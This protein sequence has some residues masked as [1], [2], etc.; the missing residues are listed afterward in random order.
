M[1]TTIKLLF[2]ALLAG[3]TAFPAAHQQQTHLYLLDAKPATAA[4]R[5]TSPHVLSVGMPTS[6]SGYDTPQMAYQR[7]P[8]ELEYYA[9]HRWADTPAHMLRPLIAAALEPHFAA[10][11]QTA[12]D[13]RLETELIRL[14]QDFTSAPSRI[15]ITLRAQLVD[16][17][18]R[19]VIATRVFDESEDSASED[20]YG[21]VQ[22][23]NRALS[24]MLDSLG[25]FC[26]E[27][28]SR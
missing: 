12:N 16:V 8:H 9:T 7:Q 14:Q 19:R 1:K 24:R 15:R 25:I 4:A 27:Q 18:N 13:L 20:A 6:L 26:S 21:G 17:K 5:A 10:V 11:S 2:A 28:A 22:A 23:A 3:C